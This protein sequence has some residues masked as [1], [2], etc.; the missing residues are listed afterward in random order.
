MVS[1]NDIDVSSLRPSDSIK[2]PGG[3]S[4]TISVLKE[5]DNDE[6]INTATGDAGSVNPDIEDE[7][8]VD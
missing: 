6:T 7:D 2:A 4:E 3:Y 1:G 8:V 5:K